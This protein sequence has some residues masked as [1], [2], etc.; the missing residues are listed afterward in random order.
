MSE[1]VTTMNFQF[2]KRFRCWLMLWRDML[3]IV[4]PLNP[5]QIPCKSPSKPSK[6]TT[7]AGLSSSGLVGLVGPKVLI[8]GRTELLG[9]WTCLYECMYIYNCIYIYICIHTCNSYIYILKLCI[10]MYNYNI[11]IYIYTEYSKYSRHSRFFA[12][13]H[14][15]H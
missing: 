2:T 8:H 10:T 1:A 11:Y 9:M 4:M 14:I 3:C 15:H 12:D 5:H 13:R 6:I 7:M